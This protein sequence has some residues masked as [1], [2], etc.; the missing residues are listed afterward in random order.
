V[1]C[2][3]ERFARAIEPSFAAPYV[4][5]FSALAFDFQV[6][7]SA[8]SGGAFHVGDVEMLG[9]IIVVTIETTKLEKFRV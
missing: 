4:P 8:V 9:H 5:P 2:S 3:N 1:F 6:I 7:T